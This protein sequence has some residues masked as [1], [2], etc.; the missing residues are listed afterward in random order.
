MKPIYIIF[1]LAAL[2]TE[3]RAQYSRTWSRLHGP[4]TGN[5]GH[6]LMHGP[7]QEIIAQ[8]FLG[9]YHTS[10]LGKTWGYTT[11]ITGYKQPTGY[12]SDW[13]FPFYQMAISPSG[14]Y[15]FVFAHQDKDS[16]NDALE[17]VYRSTDY[18][19]TWKHV[20]TLH[21][22]YQ[23]LVAKDNSIT[24]VND[25]TPG[26]LKTA[27][28]YESIDNGSSWTNLISFNMLD[29]PHFLLGKNKNGIFFSGQP[30]SYNDQHIEKF[31]PGTQTFI[32]FD[33]GLPK[34]YNGFYFATN[35]DDML[36][37]FI[38][39][40]IYTSDG[41]S[42]WDSIGSKSRIALPVIGKGDTII[43]QGAHENGYGS[44]LAMSTN[45]GHTWD[46]VGRFVA[47]NSVRG[48]ACCY[49]DPNELLFEDYD[50]FSVSTDRGGSWKAIGLP[51]ANVSR[52]LLA[53]E[54]LFTGSGTLYQQDYIGYQRSD[55]H[56]EHWINM[57]SLY[58]TQIGKG[59]GGN[60]LALQRD[61]ASANQYR[62]WLFKTS[63]AEWTKRSDSA[64]I[65]F[66]GY[67]LN[68]VSI[69]SDE[70]KNIYISG[71]ELILRSGDTGSTWTELRRD[72]DDIP[73]IAAAS[74]GTF[75][76]AIDPYIYRTEDQGAT[77]ELPDPV[78][79]SV[80]QH[81]LKTFGATGVL[82]GTY[83]YGLM[84]S[85][86]KGNSWTRI[87]GKHFDTVTCIA[88]DSKGNIAAG[89]NHG[90][91]LFDD[92]KQSWSQVTLGQDAD[93]YIGDIDV[94]KDDDFYV[95][96]HGSSVWVGT[97][98]INAV[99]RQVSI[100]N[101]DIFPNPASDHTSISL[102][103]AENAPPTAE[104]FDILGRKI[105]ITT[106]RVVPGN[107]ITLNTSGLA[108]GIY[109]IAFSIGGEKKTQKLIVRH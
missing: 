61:V 75:Y 97:T 71:N 92:T 24:V 33:E 69:V 99:P 103:S 70:V 79:D 15:Y 11:V 35:N 38:D 66:S 47:P 106:I 73:S 14:N 85:T 86:D 54:R 88:R 93:L 6:R 62:A 39:S 91:W 37:A 53:G 105:P 89:T 7:H 80:R 28:V 87:D 16:A 20:V 3:S 59:I 64:N 44:Y 65:V 100:N 76:F 81:C 98:H 46:S 68:I 30:R 43:A 41:I 32:P 74:D 104:L 107:S 18:G 4:Y 22:I 51:Y 45:G 34:I 56:G 50:A 63:S 72:F 31:D 108:D 52:V 26:F 10:D 48:Y 77:W 36:L 8:D 29:Y 1:L 84:Q 9:Y 94:S 82:L 78:N 96:T 12:T 83:G 57:D 60:L 27:I 55:D 49:D 67:P 109:T 101:V 13:Y 102:G 5:P 90:L 58:F 42:G 95:G 19:T 40:V 23:F 17:G 25:T 21:G 2:F